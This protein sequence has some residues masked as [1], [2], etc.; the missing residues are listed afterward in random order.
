M[1]TDQKPT[2]SHKVKYIKKSIIVI[3]GIFSV[4]L[5]NRINT[6]FFLVYIFPSSCC[7]IKLRQNLYSVSQICKFEK[8]LKVQVS[9][10]HTVC[11]FEAGL[12]QKTLE[13]IHSRH[14]RIM[15]TI[16]FKV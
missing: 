4:L 5:G 8:E 9:G 7:T 2:I 10:L 12:Q 6:F 11:F 1:N 14:P 3:A 15:D 13:K 16:R